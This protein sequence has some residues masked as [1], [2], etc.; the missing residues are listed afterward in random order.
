MWIYLTVNKLNGKMY[1]G[2]NSRRDL[3]YLGS[4]HNILQAIEKYGKENFEMSILEDLGENAT[5]KEVIDCENKWI[6]YF[7][8]PINS[9]F[10]NISW[11]TGGMGKGDSHTDE[12]KE[13]IRNSMKEVYKNGLPAEWRKNVINALYGR[14]SLE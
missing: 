11:N 8:A 3:D 12:T 6:E 13:L 1:V 5:L 7:Q 14:S 4:G 9:E 10:Y 2:R